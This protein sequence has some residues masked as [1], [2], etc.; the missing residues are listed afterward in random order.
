MSQVVE[1]L[2]QAEDLI[3]IHLRDY[4]EAVDADGETIKLP[5]THLM[6]ANVTGLIGRAIGAIEAHGAMPDG[7]T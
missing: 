7:D 1:Y 6:L 3:R 2:V 4:F 5:N